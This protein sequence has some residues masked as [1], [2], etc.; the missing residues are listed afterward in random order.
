MICN[1]VP[2]DESR[3]KRADCVDS[4]NGDGCRCSVGSSFTEASGNCVEAGCFVAGTDVADGAGFAC[5]AASFGV[6]TTVL[7]CNRR[8]DGCDCNFGRLISGLCPGSAPRFVPTKRKINLGRSHYR[9]YY[10][11]AG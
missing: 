4:D 8:G 10:L 1:R 6:A 2:G 11:S 5:I 7:F 3:G 9:Y